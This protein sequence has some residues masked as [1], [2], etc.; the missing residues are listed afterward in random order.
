VFHVHSNRLLHLRK[1]VFF[2]QSSHIF[3]SFKTSPEIPK[4]LV[5]VNLSGKRIRGTNLE[6][7]TFWE[8]EEKLYKT[9]I[10]PRTAIYLNGEKLADSSMSPEQSF[11]SNDL[12]K[13]IVF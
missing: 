10:F 12:I 13:G 5:Q 6:V 4:K 11:F 8:S 3:G 2:F 9:G 1:V 7:F